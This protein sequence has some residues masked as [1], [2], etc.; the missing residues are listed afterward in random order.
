MCHR[1][2]L[3]C[4]VS[5]L[6]EAI[7]VHHGSKRI[8]RAYELAIW[9]RPGAVLVLTFWVASEYEPMNPTVERALWAG[10]PVLRCLAPLDAI[11]APALG[12]YWIKTLP[13][14]GG[15]VGAVLGVFCLWIGARR[16]YRALFEFEAYRWMTLRLAKLAIAT[17]V[18]M[19]MVKLVWFIQGS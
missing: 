9:R 11:L 4:S 3:W 5:K 15:L 19:A 12:L 14:S 1:A 2:Y 17:W 10:T 8:G 7:R 18:V 16:A 13:A 6:L